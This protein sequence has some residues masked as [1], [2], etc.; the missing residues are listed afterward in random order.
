MAKNHPPF[1]R[2]KRL[3]IYYISQVETNPPRFILFVNS[4]LLL[5]DSYKRYLVN[6]IRSTFGFSGVPFSL[7]LKGKGT[8]SRRSPPQPKKGVDRDLS[9][10]AAFVEEAEEGENPPPL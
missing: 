1:I 10:V 5:D 8:S 7:H 2:G 6:N 9:S 4:P 3:R